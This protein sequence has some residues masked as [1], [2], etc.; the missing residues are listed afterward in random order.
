MKYNKGVLVSLT[1][2]CKHVSNCLF[3][4]SNR[5]NCAPHR[6]DCTADSSVCH[7]NSSI[8]AAPFSLC[9]GMHSSASLHPISNWPPIG[10]RTLNEWCDSNCRTTKSIGTALSFHSTP[11]I[12]NGPNRFHESISRVAKNS[13][14][15]F[16]V[17]TDLCCSDSIWIRRFSSLSSHCASFLCFVSLTRLPSGYFD[18]RLCHLGHSEQSHCHFDFH[19][20]GDLCIYRWNNHLDYCI[21]RCYRT[22]MPCARFRIDD[23]YCLIYDR[24]ACVRCYPCGRYHSHSICALD[25]FRCVDCLFHNNDMAQVWVDV[26]II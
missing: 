16:W 9:F 15:L 13:T 7:R 11:S 22:A 26:L 2:S 3:C 17:S 4:R 12:P 19:S 14:H 18:Y 6:F 1:A 5:H 21:V 8:R 20:T 23:Y 25:D 10:W 24:L